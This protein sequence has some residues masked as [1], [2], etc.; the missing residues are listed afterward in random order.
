MSIIVIISDCNEEII[1]INLAQ[2]EYRRNGKLDYRTVGKL[3][4]IQKNTNVNEY[5]ADIYILLD[6]KALFNK[7]FE[8]LTVEEKEKFIKYPIYSLYTIN[9]L[10]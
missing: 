3:I 6:D 2:L 4:N 10:E 7:Y 9:I 8:S 1:I 5:L